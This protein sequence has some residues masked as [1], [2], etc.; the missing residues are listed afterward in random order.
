MAR[1]VMD[2]AGHYDTETVIGV[3]GRRHG[4]LTKNRP[5]GTG[6]ENTPVILGNIGAEHVGD[7]V[8][9]GHDEHVGAFRGVR[10][11]HSHLFEDGGHR[12][13]RRLFWDSDLVLVWD[14]ETIKHSV[15]VLELPCQVPHPCPSRRLRR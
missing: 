14:F 4:G 9:V 8:Q 11:C 5:V 2:L 3:D 13:T 12:L 6:V 1:Q 10:G 15:Y 7:S